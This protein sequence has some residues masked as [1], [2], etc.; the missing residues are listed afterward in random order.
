MTPRLIVVTKGG[1]AEQVGMVR[2]L[3][4][5]AVPVV[6]SSDAWDAYD[7]PVAP[8]F[9]LV[10]GESGAVVGEGAAND[11]QQVAALLHNALDDAGMLDRKGKLKVGAKIR[12]RA[13]AE[14][15]QRVDRDLLAAGIQPG[16]PSL[17][18][19]PSVD[20]SIID[21]PSDDARPGHVRGAS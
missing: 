4:P 9:V 2:K 13:D 19:L 10:D 1:A 11:W 14:R 8:F 3:A 16:D 6:M 21:G 17:Y 5:D 15:E 18:A 20:S 12:P 7:V